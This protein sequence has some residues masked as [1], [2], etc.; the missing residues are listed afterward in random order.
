MKYVITVY[1]KVETDSIILYEIKL[2]KLYKIHG[3]LVGL[4]SV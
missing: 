2:G 1:P 3:K 4:M